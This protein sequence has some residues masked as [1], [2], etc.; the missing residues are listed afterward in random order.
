MKVLH[1]IPYL[2]KASGGVGSYLQIL[3][4]EL[5]K[6][7]DLHIV[8]HASGDLLKTVNCEVH[9][10]EGSLFHVYGMRKQF[11]QL[12]EEL[13][14]NVVHVNGCWM[15]QDSLIVF[16]AKSRNIKVVVSPHGMLEPWNIKKNYW[17]KKLPALMLYQSRSLRMADILLS[18]S[19]V[20]RD[21]LLA[22]GFNPCV[23][24]IPNGI[25]VKD[26][27]I[28][29]SWHEQ[30]CIL[31][32]ALWRHN[33]GLD[34]LFDAIAC[35]REELNEWKVKIVGLES[36]YTANQLLNM[37]MSRKIDSIVDIVGALHGED[38]LD[39]YRSADVFVLP[40]LH[41][42]FGI[43]IAESFICGTPVITTKGAPWK[44]I[45][46]NK[47]GWWVDRSVESI[48]AAI[49][50]FMDTSIEDRELMGRKGRQ[51]VID[52]YSSVAIAQQFI[53]MYSDLIRNE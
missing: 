44:E 1:Y 38:K 21:N 18:T 47:C 45:E 53:G 19:E 16:W 46:E 5:G 36:D 22:A 50:G 12:L 27:C 42:N 17:V 24:I 15:P 30:K 32:L 14:P 20:E 35:L 7:C 31:F 33:K 23:K 3:A 49:R 4:D 52:N 6:L 28:K 25:S 40:T 8:T 37:A 2:D 43:V 26:V 34:I 10:I 41:E 39:A 48:V 29:Q 13:K 9:F 11:L 51:F